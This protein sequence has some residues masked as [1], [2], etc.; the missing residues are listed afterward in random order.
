MAGPLLLQVN[1]GGRILP[2]GLS[3]SAVYDLLAKRAAAA[4]V[5]RTTPHDLRRSFATATL[6]AGADLAVTGDLLGHARTDTTKRYDRRG[7]RAR[8]A[9]VDRLHMSWT[10]RTG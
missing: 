2:A 9:A 7:E 3:G 1:K 10:R 5:K 8:R 6:D 4:D